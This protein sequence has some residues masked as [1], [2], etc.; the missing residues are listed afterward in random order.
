ML[1]E[2]QKYAI[3]LEYYEKGGGA[4]MQ[5]AW[6]APGTSAFVALPSGQ[7]YGD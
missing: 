4:T 7:L 5:L 2:G 3:K 6:K 1:L